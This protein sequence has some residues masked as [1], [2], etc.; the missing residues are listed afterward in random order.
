MPKSDSPATPG[1]TSVLKT[2]VGFGIAI[3][4][5]YL[6]GTVVGWER[7]IQRLRTAQLEWIGAACLSTMLCLAA[8]G[9]SWQIVLQ[10]LDVSVPYRKLFVT[11]LAATFANYVTPM[12]NAG[13]EPFV[14][15]VLARDTEATYEQ[16]FASVLTSDLVRLLPFFTAGGI[17]T[18]Y[19]LL[20]TQL[21]GTVKSLAYLLIGLA[22]G[23]PLIVA[24]G[25][26]FRDRLRDGVLRGVA[27]IA[28]RTNR[29][30]VASIRDRF[31]RLYSSIDIIAGSRRALFFAIVYA[32]VGWVLFALPLYFAGLAL[33]TPISIALVCFLVPAGVIAG[34][35]PLP[36]GLAAIEGTLVAL[37]TALT[38]MTTAD[39]LA[40]TTVYRLASY[41]FVVGIGGVAA[42]W[43]L[44]RV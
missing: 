31:D 11:T 34:S 20:T 21:P 13:G 9:R 22:I 43:V 44:K 24:V 26:S 27:P 42:L 2:A 37:L 5:I 8:W 30:A 40:V 1:R 28:R 18:G 29:I 32:Y 17:G 4:L 19:V 16:S 14:A 41:W 25:W 6:L 36:G 10:S 33:G 3:V 15:Y 23:L 39:S 35:T 12:G 38:A 7:T